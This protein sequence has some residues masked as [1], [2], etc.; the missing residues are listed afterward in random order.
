MS[1]KWTE[2][3][4]VGR[5][6]RAHGIRGQVIVNA[7]TDFP[8][9]RFQPGAELF[10]ERG[11]RV[12]ALIVTT[13]RFHRERPVIGIAGV[14]TMTDA[15]TLAGLELRVPVDRLAALPP[16][17]FYRHDL[18]GCRVEMRDGA[19][20]GVVTNVEGTM[21]GSRLVVEGEA[22]EVLIPLVGEICTLVDPQSKRIVVDPPAGLIEAN[23][24]G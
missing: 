22:G 17:T 23:A 16:G 21:S 5:I 1:A 12:D 10:V 6:A 8:E 4:V 24:R 13:A 19:T 14:E 18:V 20:V 2:M 9:E 7:E 15:E 3:A 11:G